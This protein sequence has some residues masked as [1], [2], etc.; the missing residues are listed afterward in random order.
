MRDCVVCNKELCK[1]T[2]GELCIQCYRNRNKV[3][4]DSTIT[5]NNSQE[6]CVDKAINNETDNTIKDD[7][8]SQER[9]IIDMLKEHMFLE[10]KRD[11]E[12]VELLQCQITFLQQEIEHKNSFIKELLNK[13][14]SI[15]DHAFNNNKNDNN[16]SHKS[17]LN[18]VIPDG[19]KANHC[20]DELVNKDSILISDVNSDMSNVLIKQPVDNKW[21]IER[22][23]N[24]KSNIM[25]S[26]PHYFESVNNFNV[27]D[28][29]ENELINAECVNNSINER[30]DC[31]TNCNNIL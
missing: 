8:E 26:T 24:K 12:L 30:V 3:N 22:R 5:D 7:I 10:K 4:H 29:R 1:T 18:T 11:A 13:V 9:D 20:Y 14:P 27:L 23:R 21:T 31:N 28:D 15:N 2:K 19:G 25:D 17:P 16:I 6:T